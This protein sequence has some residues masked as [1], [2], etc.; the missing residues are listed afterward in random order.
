MQFQDLETTQADIDTFLGHNTHIMRAYYDKFMKDDAESIKFGW[1]GIY[2]S[3]QVQIKRTCGW[4]IDPS[5]TEEQRKDARNKA[6]MIIMDLCHVANFFKNKI[7]N[8]DITQI[9]RLLYSLRFQ[10]PIGEAHVEADHVFKDNVVRAIQVLSK[11][12]DAVA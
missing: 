7:S 9:V 2:L 4:S 6:H 10:H 5:L 1:E 8:A 12:I 11:H 3:L